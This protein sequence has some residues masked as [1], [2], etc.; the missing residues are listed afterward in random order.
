[1]G[2]WVFKEGVRIGKAVMQTHYFARFGPWLPEAP[3]IASPPG[4]KEID[5][6]RGLGENRAG[7]PSPCEVEHGMKS[8]AALFLGLLSCGLA[9]AQTAPEN[10]LGQRYAADEQRLADWPELN[11]YR[12]D[13]AALPAAKSGE[14]RVVFMGDSI[15]DFWGRSVGTFFPGKP[16]VNRGIS[17]QTTAQMLIR[18]RAD[19]IALKPRVVVILAGTNDLNGNTGP[20]TLGMIEDN[21]QSM[22]ELAR[23]NGI[24]VVFASVMPVH[25]YVDPKQ[26]SRRSPQK[27]VALNAWMKGYAGREHDGYVDYYTPMLDGK[28]MLKRELSD[29]GLHPNVAG[30]AVMAPLAEAGIRQALGH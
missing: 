8:I 26:S 19:V 16:Y 1:M 21:L 7:H 17:G 20:A 24:K 12:A 30:Y 5:P 14:D 3:D 9:M 23:A 18:F 29:D 6:G 27:I 22:A 13:N 2:L 11:R 4:P 10:N 28:G 25:D 15:T